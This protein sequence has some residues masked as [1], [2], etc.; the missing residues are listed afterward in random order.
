MQRRAPGRCSSERAALNG[1]PLVCSTM[2][3]F[4]P[5]TF[6][7]STTCAEGPMRTAIPIVGFQEGSVP[8]DPM[9]QAQRPPAMPHPPSFKS[10]IGFGLGCDLD[11]GLNPKGAL[12]LS[13][14]RVQ[15]PARPSPDAG[16]AAIQ[17]P[18]ASNSQRDDAVRASS[19]P[20]LPL[21]PADKFCCS[22]VTPCAKRPPRGWLRGLGW[23]C[24]AQ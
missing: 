19:P 2:N 24:P 7:T 5:F 18:T 14:T 15:V 23:P 11:Y 9:W 22:V 12:L 13:L 4:Q 21:C 17:L 6:D 16:V 8:G 1:G 10:S 20:H 3:N